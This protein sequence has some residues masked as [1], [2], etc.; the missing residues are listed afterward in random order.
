MPLLRHQVILPYNSGLPTDVAVTTFHTLSESIDAGADHSIFAEAI[1][2]FYTAGDVG[3]A[4]EDVLSAIINGPAAHVRSY[5]LADA[6]PRVPVGDTN[7]PLTVAS[8]PECLPEEVALCLSFQGVPIS[9][10]NQA[11]RRGRV[12]LGPW[13][14]NA[15]TSTADV[16]RPNDGL[17]ATIVGRAGQ[18]ALELVTNDVEW[19]VLSSTITGFTAISQIWV[20][21]AWDTQ[22]RRGPDPTAREFLDLD[23]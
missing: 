9:G 18:L 23:A 12:Y 3:E 4:V 15:N 16:S 20:D 1:H 14:V 6:E 11:R 21:N 22:R 2:N 10:I 7:I 13:S 19:G 5:N 8:A 17:V